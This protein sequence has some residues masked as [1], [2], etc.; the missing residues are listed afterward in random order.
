MYTGDPAVWY[1]V[2][3]G[4]IGGLTM[5]IVGVIIPERVGP[6][7]LWAVVLVASIALG[8]WAMSRGVLKV[9]LFEV[10][11][12]LRAVVSGKAVSI[13]VALKPGH[14]HWYWVDSGRPSHGGPMAH[15]N[16]TVCSGD[17]R[18]LGFTQMGSAT[19]TE[20]WPRRDSGLADGTDVYSCVDLFGLQ[21]ALAAREA[22]S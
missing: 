20:T 15:F 6:W 4:A 12:A 1:L 10:D 22:A 2:V 16:L 11:G 17:G 5:T 3:L 21:R 9:S 18:V 19:K 13:D 14:D 7:W 8:A